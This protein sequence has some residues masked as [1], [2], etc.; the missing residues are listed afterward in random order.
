MF[1]PSGVCCGDELSC[2]V[3]IEGI[4]RYGRVPKGMPA[5]W[6][7]G[8]GSVAIRPCRHIPIDART[9]S[10]FWYSGEESKTPPVCDILID[11]VLCT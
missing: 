9:P 2:R 6:V 8:T 10:S 7:V 3:C 5:L 1:L 11:T 4:S